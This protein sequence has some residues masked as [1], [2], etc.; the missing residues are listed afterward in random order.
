MNNI[1]GVLCDE[2]ELWSLIE[3]VELQLEGFAAVDLELYLLADVLGVDKVDQDLD[4]ARNDYQTFYLL[5]EVLHLKKE[6]RGR[7]KR[8]KVVNQC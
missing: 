5:P 4:R 2:I 8:D 7:E 6:A 3:F 1:V